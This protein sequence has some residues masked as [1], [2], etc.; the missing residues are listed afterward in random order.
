MDLHK[1]MFRPYQT[2]SIAPPIFV[3]GQSAGRD[4]VNQEIT[5]R[6]Q[7]HERWIR[8]ELLA[9]EPINGDV[10]DYRVEMVEGAGRWV[11]CG[12][13]S[14]PSEYFREGQ[15][16]VSVRIETMTHA[17]ELQPFPWD[18]H[19]G[20]GVCHD[21]KVIYLTSQRDFIP[22]GGDQVEIQRPPIQP[23]TC[24]FCRATGLEVFFESKRDQ[25]IACQKCF[26]ERSAQYL[27]K[28]VPK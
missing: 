12:H 27:A 17:V 9:G 1:I 6:F 7:E 2:I 8:M 26:D 24:S 4:Q 10:L 16:P 13:R 23:K 11:A 15:I 5:R 20:F 19:R 25:K 21:R 22:R 18:N 14:I 28:E 3:F